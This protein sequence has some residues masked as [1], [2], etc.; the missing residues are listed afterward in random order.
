MKDYKEKKIND[1]VF[2]R[3]FVPG[4]DYPWH[5]DAEDR[6]VEVIETGSGWQFQE[7]N[8]LPFNLTA[9]EKIKIKKMVFHRL[10]S[11]SGKLIIKVTKLI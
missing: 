3:E 6:V 5:R 2:I 1:H 11:G 4:I 10:I 8:M 9:G 7:D